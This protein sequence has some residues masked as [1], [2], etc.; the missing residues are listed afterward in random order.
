MNL[1]LDSNVF[2]FVV[3]Q[4]DRL[5]ER[6]R[7]AI[8]DPNNTRFLSM[9]TPWELQIKSNLQKFDLEKPIREIVQREVDTG[10]VVMLPI[11][12]DHIDVLSRLPNHHRDPFDRMLIAQ[13]LHEGLT[14]VTSD[15]LI[16]KY[17]A[18]VLWE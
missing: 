13:A 15:E 17:A 6:A 9:A 8:V 12:L 7:T 2:I 11:A 18:P 16:A 3:Q 10:T 14:I 4:P 1:L 5:P